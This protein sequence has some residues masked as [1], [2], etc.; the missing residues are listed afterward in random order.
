MTQKSYNLPRNNLSRTILVGESR[1]DRLMT[2]GQERDQG[3]KSVTT[4]DTQEKKGNTKRRR[5]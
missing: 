4:K 2:D 1:N 3:K 5:I